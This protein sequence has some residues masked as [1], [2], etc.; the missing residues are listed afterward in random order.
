MI[1]TLSLP[2]EWTCPEFRIKT[3]VSL[4]GLLSIAGIT[5]PARNPALPASLRPAR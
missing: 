2:P 1:V 5:L 4:T 3:W